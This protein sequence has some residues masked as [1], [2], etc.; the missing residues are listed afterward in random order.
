MEILLGFVFLL[1]FACVMYWVVRM[2]VRDGIADA[3]DA[4]ARD[5]EEDGLEED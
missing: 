3:R 2:G 1:V 4:E 5:R